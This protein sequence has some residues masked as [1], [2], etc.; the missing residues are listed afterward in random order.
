MKKIINIYEINFILVFIGYTIFTSFFADLSSIVY[1]AFSLLVSLICLVLSLNSHPIIPIRLKLL[2]AIMYLMFIRVVWELLFGEY[3]DT[4]LVMT[5]YQALL[6]AIGVTG[7]PILSI[8]KSIDR[9]RWN[10][11]IYIVFILLMITLAKGMVFLN[12]DLSKYG[13]HALNERQ[14]TLTFGD[15]G[16][17]LCIL[18]TA[19]MLSYKS[20]KPFFCKKRILPFVGALGI[21]LGISSIVQAGSRGPLFGCIGALLV[22]CIYMPPKAK[23]F[24]FSSVL[25]V[26]V[27]FGYSVLNDLEE[28][29]PVLYG[30]AVDTLGEGDLGGR[31]PLYQEAFKKI[32]GSP[33][34][35]DCP[36]YLELTE[37]NSYHN[38]YIDVFVGLGLIG[39]LIYLLLN[40]K[41][42]IDVL[43]MKNSIL[44]LAYL[45]FI[46]MFVFSFIRAMSGVIIFANSNYCVSMLMACYITYYNKIN[47]KHI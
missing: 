38:C 27:F 22:L 3:S 21:M 17:Y 2:L 1:R 19:V 9:I 43:R 45:S 30:R 33:L 40:T 29:A 32:S 26:I 31:T 16:A 47:F 37:F 14:S 11:T 23:F 35:G 24:L 41:L 18:S 8:V 12:E 10:R 34:L 5:K 28:Y 7:I 4:Q 42:F 25:I 44:S 20:I 46:G 13:R 6:F 39:G 36:F 15:V